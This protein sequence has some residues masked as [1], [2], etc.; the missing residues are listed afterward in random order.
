MLIKNMGNSYTLRKVTSKSSAGISQQ[1]GSAPC[2]SK[3]K[4]MEY[5]TKTNTTK[6]EGACIISLPSDHHA[7]GIC[8]DSNLT[9][10]ARESMLH[11][12]GVTPVHLHQFPALL[13]ESRH[14]PPSSSCSS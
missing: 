6:T 8:L 11:R 1:Y 7:N 13:C 3:T 4:T 9:G 12:G 5:Q 2:K 10:D 14:F